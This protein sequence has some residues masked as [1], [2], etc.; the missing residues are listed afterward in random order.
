[1]FVAARK[2]RTENGREPKIDDFPEF[3]NIMKSFNFDVD[4]HT[5]EDFVHEFLRFNGAVL[6]SVAATIAAIAAQEI[7]KVI[8][9][10]ATP[11]GSIVIYD[12]IHGQILDQK[13]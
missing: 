5:L 3:I 11:C 13:L 9:M 10:Q 7:T 2:F 6:P 8:I 1:M 12:A 4:Q